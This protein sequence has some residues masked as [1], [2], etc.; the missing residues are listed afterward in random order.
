M[1]KDQNDTLE[2]DV[3]STDEVF[4]FWTVCLVV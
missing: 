1:L 3:K 2:E 4:G